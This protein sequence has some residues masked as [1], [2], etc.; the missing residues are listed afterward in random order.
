MLAG[1]AAAQDVYPSKPIRMIVP[2]VPGGATDLAA[3]TSADRLAAHLGQPIVLDNRGGAGGALGTVAAARAPADGYTL[4]YAPSSTML[5]GPALDPKT[6]FDTMRDFAVI[7]Q[8]VRHPMIL[9]ASATLGVSDLNG[10]R[11]TI[12]AD[13][14]KFSFGSAGAGTVSHVGSAA[15]AS[16]IG[17]PEVIHVPY[18]GTAPAIVDVIAGRVSYI[19][20]AIGPLAEHIRSGKLVGIAITSKQRAPQL[21]NLPTMAEAGLPEFLAYDWTPWSGIFV[22]KGTPPA[23]VERLNQ[24]LASALREPELGRRLIE[25]G[26]IPMNPTLAE[27]Q[28]AVLQQSTMWAPLLKKLNID[29]GS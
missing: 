9:A 24:A 27:S 15:F 5:I 25:L 23:V 19:I 1:G 14:S 29:A 13:P 4:L 7:G 10:L 28:A 26:F 11:A 16:M 8:A 21:P 22:P 2:F 6:P 18:K 12:K 3:R 17:A 20:D